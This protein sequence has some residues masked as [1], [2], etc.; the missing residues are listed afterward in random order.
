MIVVYVRTIL[1]SHPEEIKKKWPNQL[2]NKNDFQL[3]DKV[4]IRSGDG[5]DMGEVVGIKEN[6]LRQPA[7]E[8]K[9]ILR[10][11]TID[12]IRKYERRN[13]EKDKALKRVK[14]I[15]K[16]YNLPLKISQ[17]I[18]SFDGGRV[19]IVFTAP[20]R[21]DFRELVKDLS[22]RFHK[23]IRMLQIGTRDE[24][25]RLGDI[26]SC[27]CPL[28]CRAFLKELGNIP[29]SFLSDQQLAARG[30]ERMTGLCGRLKC[31]LAFEEEVYKKLAKDFPPLGKEIEA[32][33][34][35][36]KVVEWRVLKQ[37]V[38]VV[39]KDGTRQEVAIEDV[40]K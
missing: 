24:A 33:K 15:V 26:G 9:S 35:K 31:C 21:I 19:I 23:S 40:K 1:Q 28:C 22:H 36:G 39:T 32:G 27:G 11:A 38:I 29:I 34:I 14:E 17:V 20:S 7:D 5:T 12:D 37:K 4:I 2:I 6:S 25:E 10:R 8:K 30:A 18:F 16:N 13:E 3:K